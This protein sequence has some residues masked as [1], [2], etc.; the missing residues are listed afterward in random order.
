MAATR[1]AATGRWDR[2]A[3]VSPA[4]EW[5]IGPVQLGVD[6][7]GDA[8]LVWSYGE[9]AY[10]D[11]PDGEW[12][13][14]TQ[15][16]RGAYWQVA[17][18]PDGTMLLA[19]EGDGQIVAAAGSHGVWGAPVTLDGDVTQVGAPAAAIASGGAAVVIWSAFVRGNDMVYGTVRRGGAWQP[20]TNLSFV[21]G[22][23]Q[24]PDVAID[25][26]GNALAVW[27]ATVDV[28]ASY[29]RAGGAWQR[30]VAVSPP[31]RF[32]TPT[33]A[34]SP[35]G[36]AVAAWAGY[37]PD[38]GLQAGGASF[39][40]DT[41]WQTPATLGAPVS[42]WG[43]PGLAVAADSAGDGLAVWP[44]REGTAAN[45]SA[46]F[47][48]QAAVLDAG[49]PL[50]HAVSAVSRPRI[51][52]VARVGHA[53]SCS[54]G[55]WTGAAPIRFAYRWLRGGRSVASGPRHLLARRDA[56]ALLACRVTATNVFGSDVETS[57]RIRVRR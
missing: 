13:A 29:K 38:G 36:Q 39:A 2:P 18:A 24:S 42:F 28:E 50:L 20:E 34:M 41:G 23:A 19:A 48:L 57:P 26:K 4:G 1:D 16:L 25:A 53:L 35:S 45:G 21:D 43:W 17:V 27:D 12:G 31:L 8:V 14:P 7:A 56:G 47:S 3:Q 40:A 33:V 37:L 15:P 10:R 54:R 30:P 44:Q 9:T 11:G 5:A 51:V 6:A 49:G 32:S 55:R 52:G 22:Q 46:Q